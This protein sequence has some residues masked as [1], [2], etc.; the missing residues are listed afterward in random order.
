MQRIGVKIAVGWKLFGR[1]GRKRGGTKRGHRASKSNLHLPR[2]HH[3]F[4]AFLGRT[5]TCSRTPGSW[6][7][8]SRS[9]VPVLPT[10]LGSPVPAAPALPGPVVTCGP[11]TRG[12]GGAG[13]A[14]RAPPGGGGGGGGHVDVTAAVPGQPQSR[15][16]HRSASAAASPS[17]AGTAGTAGPGP[18]RGQREPPPRCRAA[19]GGGW[20]GRGEE[21]M[22]SDRGRAA[23]AAMAGPR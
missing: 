1:W 17:R 18:G 14:A 5:G 3:S 9:P 7:P 6:Q 11:G 16:R 12:A 21:P 8:R 20:A 19:A 22:R 15:Q 2:A 23:G 13:G 4:P 10:L